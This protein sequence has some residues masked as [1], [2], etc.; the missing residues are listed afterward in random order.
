MYMLMTTYTLINMLSL[1]IFFK[2]KYIF[3][4]WQNFLREQ[5]KNN[6]PNLPAFEDLKKDI[7]L[8]QRTICEDR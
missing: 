2:V 3:K 6:K 4:L 5:K 1:I 8:I 7:L